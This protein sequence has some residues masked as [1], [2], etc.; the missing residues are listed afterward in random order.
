MQKQISEADLNTEGKLVW[1]DLEP[2]ASNAMPMS[3]DDDPDSTESDGGFH[4]EHDLDVDM[5]MG[6]DVDAPDSVDL[7]GDVDMTRNSDN[8][9]EEYE[10]EEEDKVEEDEEKEEDEVEVEDDGKGPQTISQGEMVN[11][12]ADGEDSMADNQ[13]IVLPEQ[14]LEMRNLTP[15]PHPPVAAP[16]PQTRE[17]RPGP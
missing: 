6:A 16:L 4:T 2:E 13:R 8:E 5:C 12:A 10:V 1:L 11:T 7:D 9:E 14:G 3:L 15:G 17:P